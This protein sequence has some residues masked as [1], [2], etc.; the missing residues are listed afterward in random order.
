MREPRRARS[1]A[2][3]RAAVAARLA[4]PSTAGAVA[5]L[6]E[7]P[8]APTPVG[9]RTSDREADL[10]AQ[11]EMVED[12]LDSARAEIFA[13]QRMM[14]TFASRYRKDQD[15]PTVLYRERVPGN[16]ASCGNCIMFHGDP[17]GE[18]TCDLVRGVIDG[19]GHW[20]NYWA[21]KT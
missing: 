2:D 6:T 18:G 1:R 16:P 19:P 4:T 20:C 3:E 21:P 7:A 9:I 8:P 13:Y 10:R 5:R 11:L 17:Q 14:V 12:E 15:D